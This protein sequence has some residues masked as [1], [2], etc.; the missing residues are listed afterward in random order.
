MGTAKSKAGA[1]AKKAAKPAVPEGTTREVLMKAAIPLFAAKGPAGTSVRDIAK[2]SGHNVATIHYH[3]GNKEGLYKA[4]LESFGVDRL[5]MAQRVLQPAQSVEELR[6]RLKMFGEELFTAH[7][8]SP[9][10]CA[11]LHRESEMSFPIAE[12][13]F[14]RTF[15]QV[16]KTLIEFLEAARRKGIVR[17]DVPTH[18]IGGILFSTISHTSRMAPI[19][20]KFFPM[21]L[22]QAEERIR[23]LD[24]FL[25]LYL[26]GILLR[27]DS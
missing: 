13:V 4:C 25:D 22:S 11:L 18:I 7:F 17:K 3:F 8:N 12:D 21:D 14:A 1:T 20:R 15:L 2:A 6:L 27:E 24:S 5:A 26:E 9:D 19:A 23:F 10:V 16:F